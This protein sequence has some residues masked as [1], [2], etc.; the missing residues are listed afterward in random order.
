MN[1]T[2]TDQPIELD[3]IARVHFEKASEAGDPLAHEW[4]TR[5]AHEPKSTLLS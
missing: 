1:E 4:L 3:A 2:D 5:T